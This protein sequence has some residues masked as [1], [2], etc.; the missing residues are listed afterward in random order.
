MHDIAWRAIIFSLANI[1]I[2]SGP[3]TLWDMVALMGGRI[4]DMTFCTGPSFAIRQYQ[5]EA[6]G[7]TL[8]PCTIDS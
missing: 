4:D 3:V 2:S 6:S 1:I 7:P 5:A 8:T